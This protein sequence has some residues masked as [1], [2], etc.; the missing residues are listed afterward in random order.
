MLSIRDICSARRIGWC[1]DLLRGGGKRGGEG[2]GIDVGADAVEV[3]LGEPEHIHAERVAQLCFVQ[4]L[5]D[6]A[7]I[8]R[9]VHRGREQEIAES[10]EV[11]Y[12]S[13]SS[14]AATRSRSLPCTPWL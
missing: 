5:L 12:S 3:V 14:G 8:V 1:L 6:H 7:L 2:D 10:H 4:R 9:R 11:P 13:R